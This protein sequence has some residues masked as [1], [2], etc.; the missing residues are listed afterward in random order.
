[1]NTTKYT[2]QAREAQ[3]HQL[4]C[5]LNPQQHVVCFFVADFPNAKRE[6]TLVARLLSVEAK[7]VE[8]AIIAKFGHKKAKKKGATNGR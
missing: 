6:A 5:V 3:G 2:A 4:W 7:R 8:A 1:M